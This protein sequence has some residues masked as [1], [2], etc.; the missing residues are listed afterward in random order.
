ML[1]VCFAN[2]SISDEK[3]PDRTLCPSRAFRI[4][5]L[6]AFPFYLLLSPV[7]RRAGD[8]IIRVF[9]YNRKVKWSSLP[10]FHHAFAIP[11]SHT[12][13]RWDSIR[14]QP[15]FPLKAAMLSRFATVEKHH[16]TSK[17]HKC[18]STILILKLLQR[19]WRFFVFFS[20]K[21]Y[22]VQNYGQIS[23]RARGFLF[24]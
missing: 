9:Y 24:C 10:Q 18:S 13:L 21:K 23:D 15:C 14:K 1:L 8:V 22:F 7:G 19:L 6:L 17:R 2:F 16:K 4:H 20:Y 5:T 3:P 12:W 11:H